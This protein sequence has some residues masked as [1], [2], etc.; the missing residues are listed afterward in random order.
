M[1]RIV[2]SAVAGVAPEQM[3]IGP[4]PATRKALMRAGLSASDIGLAELNEAFAAQAVPCMRELGLDPIDRQYLRAVRSR[5][6]TRSAVP[7]HASS[8]RSCTG[9]AGEVSDTASPPCASAW[10]RGSR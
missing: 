3:G 10:A 5:S 2:A 4:V 9:C 6:V 7:A 8:P 1:A